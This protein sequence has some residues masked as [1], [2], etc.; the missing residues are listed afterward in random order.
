MV[1][2]VPPD[3]VAVPTL[4]ARLPTLPRLL[5]TLPPFTLSVPV[6]PPPTNS[7]VPLA[8]VPLDTVAMP[9]LPATKPMVQAELEAMQQAAAQVV[10]TILVGTSQ[11]GIKLQAIAEEYKGVKINQ[12]TP[13]TILHE[14]MAKFPTTGEVKG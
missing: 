14:M 10:E 4:P 1:F 8:H 6:P 9:M 13:A 5:V 12:E 2:H 7:V 3:T 11:L